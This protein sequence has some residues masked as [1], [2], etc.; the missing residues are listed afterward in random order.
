MMPMMTCGCAAQAMCKARAGVMLDPPI[1]ACLTHECYDIDP[2]QPSLEGRKARCVYY[3]GKTSKRGSY[4][5]GN[6]CNYG[7]REY[8]RCT[9]EQPSDPKLPFF[10]YCGAGTETSRK[11]KCGFF[12][13]AH[14]GPAAGRRHEPCRKFVAQGALEIDEFYCGCHGWD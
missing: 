9:C 14:G 4:G 5:G 8:A 11:C 13:S 7:Q 2:N 1:P 12:E 3:G 6:E 10:T